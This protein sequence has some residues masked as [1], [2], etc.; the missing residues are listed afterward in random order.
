MISVICVWNN[1]V[2]YQK[3]LIDSLQKQNCDY[4]LFSIDNRNQAFSSCDTALN[5]GADHSQ[6]DVLVF[7]NQDITTTSLKEFGI[8]ITNHPDMVV[9]AYGAK[10]KGEICEAPYLCETVDECCF[11]MTCECFNRLRFNEEVCDGWDLYAV[12]MCLRGKDNVTRG[13]GG[14]N[15]GI[16]HFSG[17]N[18][19]SNYM[20]K[21]KQ[22]LNIYHHEGYICTTCESMP[23]NLFYYY[24]YFSI[25]SIKKKLLGNYP[26]VKL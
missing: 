8:F 15:P 17:G 12:E 18:I 1:E 7:V 19:D 21:F 20:I 2:Q 16:K 23:C 25:W 24:V 4:E 11:E 3:I 5:W 13:E 22:L 9:G 14:Y 26:S 6:G 10:Q